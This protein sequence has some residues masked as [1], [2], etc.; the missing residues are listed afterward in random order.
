[1]EKIEKWKR[2][3][4]Y[5][6]K[7]A[8]FQPWKFISET[9][10]LCCTKDKE[11]IYFS[12][13]GKNSDEH[14]V[15]VYFNAV[16]FILG[17]HKL[18]NNFKNEPAELMQN[19]VIGFWGNREDVSKENY[20]IIRKLGYKFRGKGCW[21]FF[22]EYEERRFPHDVSEEKLDI[23]MNALENLYMLLKE[24]FETDMSVNFEQGHILVREYLEN[25]TWENNEI[26]C[27]SSAFDISNIN[28]CFSYDD[29]D[30][31]RELKGM[32][33]SDYSVQ[34]DERCMF[35]P[36]NEDDEPD[37][38]VLPLFAVIVNSE[39]GAILDMNVEAKRESESVLF[40]LIEE[41]SLKYGKPRKIV[42][43]DELIF[44]RLKDFCEKI[45]I[46]LKL[47]YGTLKHIENAFLQLIADFAGS[48]DDDEFSGLINAT[49][50]LS[51]ILGS[52]DKASKIINLDDERNNIEK[53]SKSSAKG[54]EVKNNNLTYVISVSI[55]RGCYRHIKISGRETLERL[56]SEILN[57]FDFCDDHAHAFFL[58]NKAWSRDNSYYSSIIEEEERYTSEYTIAQVLSSDQKFLYI[59]DFG[60]EWRF[61]CK[62]LKVLEESCKKTEI[63]RTCGESP[64]QY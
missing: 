62:V 37:E 41:L 19:A 57:A 40:D 35:I 8:D 54:S 7:I 59:F 46:K 18:M 31:L 15:A 5:M 4:D 17:R 58:D 38:F 39:T 24:Y 47:K 11:E 2:I 9:D 14:A 28:L 13:M 33:V 10:I 29:E 16:D 23:L 22:E 32:P 48:L 55:G 42:I 50:G 60:D 44:Y 56:H 21:L 45:G 52:G 1:M 34:L 6:L 3:Y 61:N 12:I 30:G 36:V 49:D 63:V 43:N 51:D 53:K 27:S 26:S 25:G 20:Q 64:E